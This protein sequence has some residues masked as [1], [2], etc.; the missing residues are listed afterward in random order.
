MENLNPCKKDFENDLNGLLLNDEFHIDFKFGK[1]KTQ[2]NKFFAK[3]KI[4]IMSYSNKSTEKYLDP[5]LNFLQVAIDKYKYMV[6]FGPQNWMMRGNQL[7]LIDPFWPDM[8]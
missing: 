1:N 5:I 4:L 6:D 2:D 3:L 8:E 7:V